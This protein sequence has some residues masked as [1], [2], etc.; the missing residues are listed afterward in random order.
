MHIWSSVIAQI[1]K[2]KGKWDLIAEEKSFWEWIWLF[3]GHPFF[4]P[5]CGVLS[6]IPSLGGRGGHDDQEGHVGEG[7]RGG[8]GSSLL[9]F[10]LSFTDWKEISC[11]PS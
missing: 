2:E 7:G 10:N 1:R 6:G 9:F 8:H 5:I 3:G 11:K 4:C